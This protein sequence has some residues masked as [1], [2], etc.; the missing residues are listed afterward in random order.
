M[1]QIIAAVL[2]GLASTFPAV[3]ETPIERGEYIVRNVGMCA[4][5]HTP[6]DAK[7]VLIESAWLKGAP[8]DFR[9]LHPMPFATQA[10]RIA[11]MPSG[12]T[13][14][15]LASFLQTGTRADGS[16]ARP[17]MPGYRLSPEDAAAVVAYLRS[18][19]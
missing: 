1:R 3:A 4:D 18:L 8:L 9:P 19:R 13:P 17:P 12:Y 14:E 15:R 16:P 2:L 7:G 10:P 5:C 6:R 11:G